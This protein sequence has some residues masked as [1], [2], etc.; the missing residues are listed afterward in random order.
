MGTRNLRRPN[1]LKLSFKQTK[2][3]QGNALIIDFFRIF[4]HLKMYLCAWVK[5]GGKTS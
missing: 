1:V 3:A 4:L 5:M 2:T